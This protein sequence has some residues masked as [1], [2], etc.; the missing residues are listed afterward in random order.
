ML[1][2]SEQWKNIDGY[3][4]LYEVS[5]TGHLR[6][7]RGRVLTAHAQNS[8]YMQITLYPKV[9]PRTKYLMHRLVATTFIP[10]PDGK[11]QVNHID[12][13]KQ[14]NHVSNLEWSTV[15]EN[16]LHARATGLN[17]YNNPTLGK[18]IGKTSSYH[19]VGYDKQRQKWYSAVRVNGVNHMQRRFITEIAAAMHYDNIL[20][21]LALTNRPRNFTN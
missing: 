8:G 1:N 11:P 3:D 4:G 18:K 2:D 12:G 17:P 19:G 13:N 9:G 15:S 20:D 14:N 10:N 21:E 16:I 5:N 6:N 7:S